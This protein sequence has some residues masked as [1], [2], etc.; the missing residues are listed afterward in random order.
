MTL[1]QLGRGARLTRG[2]K[3]ALGDSPV[4]HHGGAQQVR[5]SALRC[6]HIVNA[7]VKNVLD[8]VVLHAVDG[9]L[10]DAAV[11]QFSFLARDRAEDNALPEM[12]MN[13]LLGKLCTAQ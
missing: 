13:A 6:G 3:T 2:G 8:S 7:H 5:D 9:E 1:G 11:G 10:T 4:L 12:G